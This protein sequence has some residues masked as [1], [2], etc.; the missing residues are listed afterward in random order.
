MC[1]PQNKLCPRI[2][3]ITSNPNWLSLN[4]WLRKNGLGL[5]NSDFQQNFIGYSYHIHWILK[6]LDFQ[7][8][9][10]QEQPKM[11]AYVLERDK[12]GIIIFSPFKI[13]LYEIALLSLIIIIYFL[14]LEYT[15]HIWFPCC[16]KC[17]W[18]SSF[19]DYNQYF[20]FFLYLCMKN[21]QG[22]LR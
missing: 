12:K 13:F 11:C 16:I 14:L 22:I 5:Y 15:S 8:P 1:F 2:I 18:L 6:F 17:I 21:Y 3:S 9:S 4:N 19:Q 20:N 7:D 10:P